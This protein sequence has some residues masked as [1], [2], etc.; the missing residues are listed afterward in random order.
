MFL[1]VLASLSESNFRLI[2]V[3]TKNNRVNVFVATEKPLLVRFK[4][5]PRSSE[6]G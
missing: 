4:T 1:D 2:V 6:P 5:K 3:A